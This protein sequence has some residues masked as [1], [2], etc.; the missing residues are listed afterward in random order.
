MTHSIHELHA[1]DTHHRVQFC[2]WFM[3]VRIWV[4]N[5]ML[6]NEECF[7]LN[8]Y[9]IIHN[10][11]Y[12]AQGNSHVAADALHQTNPR[13]IVWHMIHGNSLFRPVFLQGEV[14]AD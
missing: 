11:E 5:I 8:G 7:H 1:D 12:W 4:D 13:I 6:S 9:V 2:E 14:K 10:N 3:A